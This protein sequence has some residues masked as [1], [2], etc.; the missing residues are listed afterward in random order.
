MPMIEFRVKNHITNS[1]IGINLEFAAH[2]SPGKTN[3]SLQLREA[4][5]ALPRRVLGET[6][7]AKI[8]DSKKAVSDGLERSFQST[9]ARRFST[10]AKHLR[11]LNERAAVAESADG[12]NRVGKRYSTS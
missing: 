6:E 1:V 2:S 12:W 8:E 5:I 11:E 3:S 7:R 9:G 10:P 4:A